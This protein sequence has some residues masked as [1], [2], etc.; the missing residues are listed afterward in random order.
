MLT[1]D[2]IEEENEM[3]EDEDNF[4]KE[5]IG[6][7]KVGD[8][9]QEEESNFD[10]AGID[11][12]DSCVKMDADKR[13]NFESASLTPDQE[14]SVELKADEDLLQ[15]KASDLIKNL[16]AE[17]KSEKSVDINRELVAN[18][19]VDESVTR[20]PHLTPYL[21]LNTSKSVIKGF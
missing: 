3:L 19:D 7:K 18:S 17:K 9:S 10:I 6:Q 8:A 1:K 4:Q 16:T 14:Q 21:S 15:E 5:K 2:Q 12:E 11:S 20:S 13:E